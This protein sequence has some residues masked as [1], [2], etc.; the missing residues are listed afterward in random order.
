MLPDQ[1]ELSKKIAAKNPLVLVILNGLVDKIRLKNYF[2]NNILS[3]FLV[4]K[5]GDTCIY[6]S[7][8]LSETMKPQYLINFFQ[9]YL[10]ALGKSK[11]ASKL[12][13]GYSN[14]LLHSASIANN[15]CS[16][17]D[18]NSKCFEYLTQIF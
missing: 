11:Q 10:K 2:S 12:V 13:L 18:S 16:I 5:Y 15:C 1:V 4:S 8:S 17:A 3:L 9:E 7:Q 6:L 14:V